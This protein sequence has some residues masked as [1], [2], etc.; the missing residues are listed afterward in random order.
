MRDEQNMADSGNRKS[1]ESPD[2]IGTAYRLTTGQGDLTIRATE[3]NRW[4]HRVKRAISMRC[5]FK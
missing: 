5:N 1:E 3:T 2:S 4:Q